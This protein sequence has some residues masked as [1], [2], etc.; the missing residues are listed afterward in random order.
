M[1][2]LHASIRASGE[3]CGQPL[4]VVRQWHTVLDLDTLTH[5]ATLNVITQLQCI[6]LQL[7]TVPPAMYVNERDHITMI[8]S[9]ER[10]VHRLTPRVTT[11][12]VAT[13]LYL[14]YKH[15][16]TACMPTLLH[17]KSA[18]RR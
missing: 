10:S 4:V 8:L 1:Q 17:Y 9:T 18:R 7:L 5:R 12:F 15:H 14:S 11:L 3:D 16:K 2:H 6:L 13:I